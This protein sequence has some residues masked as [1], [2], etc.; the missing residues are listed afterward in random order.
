MDRAR[1]MD[2]QDRYLNVECVQCAHL[3]GRGDEAMRIVKL[4]L[5]DGERMMSLYDLQG[6]RRRRG[7]AAALSETRVLTRWLAQ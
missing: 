7:E 1:Q 5:R 3:S 2:L 6:A 4:F